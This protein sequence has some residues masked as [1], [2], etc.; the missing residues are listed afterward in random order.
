MK[1]LTRLIVN[2]KLVVVIIF[3]ILT[4]VSVVCI[5]FVNINYDDTAY[6]PPESSLKQ[7]LTAMYDDFGVGGNATMM[8]SNVKIAD[9]VNMNVDLEKITGVKEMMWVDDLFLS[10]IIPEETF[11]GTF[12]AGKRS[13]AQIF[14]KPND[15]MVVLIIDALK[16]IMGIPAESRVS[17]DKMK[18][19]IAE[20]QTVLNKNSAAEYSERWPGY[21]AEYKQFYN[22][23]ITMFGL[24]PEADSFDLNQIEMIANQLDGFYKKDPNN[25]GYALVQISFEDSDYDKKTLKAIDEIEEYMKDSGYSI[26]MVG[27][28]AITHN[29][30]SV[31][32]SETTNAMV[33]AVLIVLAVLLLTTTSYWEAILL[34]IPMGV[35]ILMNMGSNLLMPKISYMTN[36]IASVLQLALTMDYS[37]LLL[38]RFKQEKK[39]GLSSN[40]AMADAMTR[41]MRAISSA[42]LT[43]IASFVALMFMGYR[44]GLDM[45]I[46]LAKGVLFSM[47][48]VFLLLPVL[49]LYTEK[50]ITKTTH[51]TFNLSFRK[52]SLKLLKHRLW[53]PVAL[54]A[55]L[56]IGA[57]FQAQNSFVYGQESSMGG[58]GTPIS[59]ARLDVE[60]IFGKQNQ[61]L[62]LLNYKMFDQDGNGVLDDIEKAAFN[63]REI[64]LSQQLVALNGVKSVQC[65]AEIDAAGASAILPESY[66]AQFL[67]QENSRMILFLDV[68]EEGP[69]TT[70]VVMRINSIIDEVYQDKIDLTG[71]KPYHIG[72]SASTL[73]IQKLVMADYDIITYISLALVALIVMLAFKSLILPILLVVTI[74]GAIYFNMAIPYFQ[75]DP[76]VFVGYLLV[77]AILLGATIDYAIV[78][79]SHYMEHRQNMNKYDAMQHSLADSARTL[80]TS[81][82]ILTFAGLALTMTTSAPATAVFGNAI[83]RGGILSFLFV[84]TL[85][86]QL[87]VIFDGLIRA[88]TF[89]GK[90]IMMDNRLCAVAPD[91]VEASVLPRAAKKKS[92]S[93]IEREQEI[94]NA[95]IAGIESHNKESYERFDMSDKKSLYQENKG[96][97]LIDFTEEPVTLFEE[98]KKNGTTIETYFK[99]SEF[100][101]PEARKKVSKK[102]A[103]PNIEILDQ[104]EDGE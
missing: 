4:V 56:A 72:N 43:T 10:D 47:F 49:T 8:V 95:I 76:L 48:S 69:E 15:K 36:S 97:E 28:A 54:I 41:S 96:A 51:K 13:L 23:A 55:L 11:E 80:M 66:S 100:I 31:M 9:M 30:V 98:D 39:R 63:E 74:Q 91:V 18:A 86:P 14:S 62:V 102:K 24:I 82:G 77:S 94:V 35:S 64:L 25:N 16:M 26:S 37:I 65:W 44:L 40:E 90:K 46:V 85:L 6:L 34:L 42:S 52:F 38:N 7:G 58:E 79:T 61:G 67:G 101:P 73:V 2:N 104:N 92:S 70:E 3:A 5:P 12:L 29:S 68:P 1:K 19:F 83:F 89:R 22:S 60:S 84:I 53:M 87:L 17:L 50:L 20:N 57:V 21:D 88:T 27:N 93:Q 59:A 78:V 75:Q 71:I 103:E 99:D 32:T 81:A 33:L 45:G